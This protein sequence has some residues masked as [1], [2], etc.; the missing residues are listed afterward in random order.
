MMLLTRVW[1]L[2]GERASPD[3]SSGCII[4]IKLDRRAI[5]QTASLARR[6]MP[7]KCFERP[8][9]QYYESCS[10]RGDAQSR[11]DLFNSSAIQSGD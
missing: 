9:A 4:N 10:M 1:Q 11:S 3:S 8:M 2:A 6:L 5:E 7:Q